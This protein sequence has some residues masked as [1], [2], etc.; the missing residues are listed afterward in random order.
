MRARSLLSLASSAVVVWLAGL[1]ALAT[2]RPAVHAMQIPAADWEHRFRVTST[3]FQN[4]TEV[5][6]SMV[7]S[8]CGGGNQSPELSWSRAPRDTRSF[9]VAMFDVTANFTHWGIYNISREATGLPVNAGVPGSSY[10]QQITNDFGN[11]EYDGPCPPAGLVHHYVI[12]VYA[13]DTE[14]QLPSSA[15]FP[16]NA[17]TLFRNL[18][19]HVLDSA[20]ITGLYSTP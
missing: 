16:A 20:S 11:M 8:G 10:G 6:M 7:Y 12:T 4:G 9:A 17:E 5:P 1:G 18:I 3:T 15:Q 14:L 13:L 2:M 19:G